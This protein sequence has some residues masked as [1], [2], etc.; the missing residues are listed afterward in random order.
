VLAPAKINLG[1]RI[2]GRRSDGYHLLDSFFVPLTLAD[3]LDVEIVAGDAP[4]GV[5]TVELVR[6]DAERPLSVGDVPRD[7]TNLA[8]R[9]AQ[10][11]LAA[12]GEAARGVAAVRIGLRKRIPVAAGL[13]GGSSDA[14][15]VLRLLARALPDALLAEALPGIAL[16]IGAD[17]P[18]FLDPRPARVRGV[19]E[20]IEPFDGLPQ[21]AIVLANPG[22][23]LSTAEV[24]R[25][26]DALSES[27]RAGLTAPDPGPTMR[28]LSGLGADPSALSGL[29][30]FANDLEAAAVRLCPPVA[31][32][33]EGLREAGALWS[34][35]SGSGAT[36]FGVFET[37]AEAVVVHER[38]AELLPDAR[39]TSATRSMAAPS[40]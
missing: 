24:Y 16:S 2:V 38:A 18:F 25:V 21:L 22:I 13:G 15:T 37:E 23:S 26:W 3:E 6:V 9:A 4:G 35:M 33:R 29:P 36:V 12:A 7:A 20:R 40:D 28:A 34:G 31:R 19:G 8:V 27:T 30:C 10:I 1:L 32:L 5:P 11:F 14:A 39:W 17:V